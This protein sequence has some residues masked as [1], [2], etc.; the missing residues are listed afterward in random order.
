MVN[1]LVDHLLERMCLAA[2]RENSPRPPVLVL[3]APVA[4]VRRD[5]LDADGAN[6]R[7]L[8]NAL[9]AKSRIALADLVGRSR[10]ATARDVGDRAKAARVGI[11]LDAIGAADRAARFDGVPARFE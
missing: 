4:S 3:L 7:M 5:H 8:R 2:P 1:H 9:L 10:C 11:D 6:F